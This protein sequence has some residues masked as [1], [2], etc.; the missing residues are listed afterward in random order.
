[1][2]Y[3]TGPGTFQPAVE[4]TGDR[5][6]PPVDPFETLD[7]ILPELCEPTGARAA[8]IVQEDADGC[9]AVAD[10]GPADRECVLRAMGSAGMSETTIGDRAAWVAAEG[11]PHEGLLRVPLLKDADMRLSAI[12][13]FSE[14]PRDGAQGTASRLSAMLTSH[15]RYFRLWH[16]LRREQSRSRGLSAALNQHRVGVFI[17]SSDRRLLFS[18][19]EGQDILRAQD[20]L[21]ERMG[22]LSAM[23]MKDA[24][25]LQVAIE[26]V[27]TH[28]TSSPPGGPVLPILRLARSAERQSL[29]VAVAAVGDTLARPGDAAAVLFVM[30][31]EHDTSRLL[32][33]V[34]QLHGLSPVETR[35]VCHLLDGLTVTEAADAMRVKGMTARSYLKQVFMKTG[36]R[37]QSELVRM[38]MGSALPIGAGGLLQCLA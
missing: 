36:A 3:Q 5:I 38:M 18:N 17:L 1:M 37:R 20:G 2:N 10:D 19:R 25:R 26:H 33:P 11:T 4:R 31:P 9:T 23:T 7:W 24:L 6:A 34:C 32:T 30:R 22:E 29:V 35:L 15:R 21:R 27:L 13:L 16:R 28:A 8:V 14:R 12:L